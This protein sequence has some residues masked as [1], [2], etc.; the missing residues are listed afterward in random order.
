MRS[1]SKL[2]ESKKHS[3][4]KLKMLCTHTKT[5]RLPAHTYSG[6]TLTLNFCSA[7]QQRQFSGWRQM[8]KFGY[9]VK[10]FP[11]CCCFFLTMVYKGY[12]FRRLSQHKL[13]TAPARH[14][15]IFTGT[16]MGG[17]GGLRRRQ[18][19]FTGITV[20]LQPAQL[21]NKKQEATHT[22]TF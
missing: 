3:V 18:R 9:N 11:L 13:Q 5:N 7:I 14:C 12:H 22:V 2:E 1:I 19:R 6:A 20:I 17:A 16:L 21:V 4:L 8:A 10:P 15:L